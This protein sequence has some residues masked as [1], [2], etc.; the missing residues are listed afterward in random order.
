ML[1]AEI[2]PNSHP[3]GHQFSMLYIYIYTFILLGLCMVFLFSEDSTKI[4]ELSAR[5]TDIEVVINK[6]YL[7]Y[8]PLEASFMSIS[9][10]LLYKVVR[11]MHDVSIS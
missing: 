11:F 6:N 3:P 9:H 7:C 4:D 10:A 2:G 1:A 8:T 5:I